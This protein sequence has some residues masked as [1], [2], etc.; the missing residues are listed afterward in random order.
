MTILVKL[1]IT[2]NLNR[3]NFDNYELKSFLASKKP[4]KGWLIVCGW[5]NHGSEQYVEII[6]TLPDDYASYN[7]SMKE[8]Q[9]MIFTWVNKHVKELNSTSESLGEWKNDWKKYDFTF[10][11]KES[12]EGH[13]FKSRGNVYYNFYSNIGWKEK[14]KSSLKM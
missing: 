12:K 6:F 4:P 5:G 3:G 14:E 2:T 9:D 1:Q 11:I 13:M 8:M 10:R 7:Y